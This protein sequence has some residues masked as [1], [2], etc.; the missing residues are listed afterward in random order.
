LKFPTIDIRNIKTCKLQK[1]QTSKVAKLQVVAT[2]R[3]FLDPK[4]FPVCEL[5]IKSINVSVVACL[6]SC[7][8]VCEPV[9]LS[10]HESVGIGTGVAGGSISLLN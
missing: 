8:F 10:N 9:I 1:L 6:H 7:V 3:S 5:K 2:L 4:T